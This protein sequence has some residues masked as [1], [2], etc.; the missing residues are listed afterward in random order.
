MRQLALT[1]ARINYF[2]VAFFNEDKAIHSLPS[3]RYRL[4]F[5]VKFLGPDFAQ[6]SNVLGI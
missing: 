1:G 6:G 4:A 5:W 3:L 2:H